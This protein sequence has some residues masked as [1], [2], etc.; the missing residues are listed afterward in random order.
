MAYRNMTAAVAADAVLDGEFA[1]SERYWKLRIGKN[2]LFYPRLRHTGYVPFSEITRAFIRVETTLTRVCC[3]PA[4]FHTYRLI[5]CKDGEEF[6]AIEL[7]SEVKADRVLA[8]IGEKGVPTGTL[9][10]ADAAAV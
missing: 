10:A 6:A 2:Y 7:D 1:A 3:G 4:V 9:Q 5:L 8:A